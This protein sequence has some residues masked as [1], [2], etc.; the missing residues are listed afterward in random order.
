MKVTE[1]RTQADVTADNCFQVFLARN[2]LFS[3][4]V[5]AYLTMLQLDV[6]NVL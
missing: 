6:S 2:G 1:E 4:T 5:L 3:L